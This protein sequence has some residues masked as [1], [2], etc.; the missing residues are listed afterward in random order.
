MGGGGMGPWTWFFFSIFFTS[1]SLFS[2]KW[3]SPFCFCL[4]SGS[5][6]F[7]SY[8]STFLCYSWWTLCLKTFWCRFWARQPKLLRNLN[9]FLNVGGGAGYTLKLTEC[10]I[11]QYRKYTVCTLYKYAI[12]F[13]Y[14]VYFLISILKIYWA[15]LCVRDYHMYIKYILFTF[16]LLEVIR[17]TVFIYCSSVSI[18]L[19]VCI[20]APASYSP[21]V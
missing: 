8:F 19:S 2:R 3:T 11:L 21:A 4:N 7:M 18:E 9:Y 16:N 14:Y 13:F 20:T 10:H 6:S 15:L 17:C 1:F 5:V 12:S